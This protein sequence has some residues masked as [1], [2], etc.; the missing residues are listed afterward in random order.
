MHGVLLRG[1]AI[2]CS[3]IALLCATAMGH[4]VAQPVSDESAR[5]VALRT[6]FPG[7]QV[8][9]D[10][11]KRIDDSWPEK[12]KAGELFFPDALAGESVY[13]V[14][15]G[16]INEAELESSENIITG[17][18]SDARQVRFRL[19]RWP[20]END[21]GMLAIL[22]YDFPSASPTMSC[23]SI[24]LLVHLVRY[25]AKWAVKDQYL[26]ETVHHT[27]L[28]GIRLLDLTGNGTDDDLVIE[29]NSGGAGTADTSLQVFD[30]SHGNLDE[31]L[32]TE[33]R[34]QYM[35]D[36][37]YSQTLDVNRTRESHGQRFCFL[38][39]TLFEEGKAFRPPRVTR[40]CYQRG[41]RVD[42]GKVRARNKM[43]TSC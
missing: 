24:G 43:P 27:S 18:F 11:S 30:L 26:L 8:S 29:S 25:A 37:W 23:P 21:T 20:K 41:D 13:T 12:P 1:F 16:A 14:A 2:N 22:Q 36:D 35:T 39:T 34:M 17:K 40:P 33:S 6:I 4:D 3:A 19:F 15:G 10:R 7:M 5:L 42:S 32:D 31:I 9:L 28:Q 38:K